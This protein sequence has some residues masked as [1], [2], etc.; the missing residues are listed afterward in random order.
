VW[1]NYS[2]GREI[3]EG[4]IVDNFINSIYYKLKNVHD[5][6]VR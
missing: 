6:N 3:L 4:I 2:R 1:K 5:E